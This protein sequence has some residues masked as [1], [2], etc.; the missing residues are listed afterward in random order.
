MKQT[1]PITCTHCG[2]TH[3]VPLRVYNQGRKYCSRA[4]Y[5]AGKLR[6]AEE[7]FWEKVNKESGHW[8]NGIQ[9]WDW[10]AA[11]L[12]RGYG[13]FTPHKEQFY[14]HRYAY[15]LLRG[16][17]PDG[18]HCLHHCDRP[19]CVNPAHHFLGTRSDN[20]RDMVAKGRA[21]REAP[22]GEASA[23]AKL[24]EDKVRAI[25]EAVACGESRSAVGRRFGI[26]KPTV[27][28]IVA[29]RSWKHVA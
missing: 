24:T 23:H 17:I 29:R 1:Y 21:A 11:R 5:F 6:P 25:R 16:L 9:C 28:G 19:C 13:L 26:S 2:T 18:L 8:W 10:T 14:A 15:E 3:L 20:M 22:R 12:P 4:C 7:R 27:Q